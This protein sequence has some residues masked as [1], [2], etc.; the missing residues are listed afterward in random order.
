MFFNF[1]AR[2]LIARFYSPADYGFFNLYFTILSIFASIGAIGLKAGIQR[3][4][5]YHLGKDEEE[6]VPAIIGWGIAI[7]L[8]G[9]FVSGMVLFIFANPI[10]SIF[11][12]DPV[13]GYYFKIAAIAVPFYILTIALESIF[14][15][16][17]RTKERILFNV[18]GRN[19]LILA[20]ILIVGSFAFHFEKMMLAV[21]LSFIFLAISF[22]IYYLKKRKDILGIKKAFKW[23]ISIGKKLFLFSLPL[24]LVGLS[25]RVM[26][27]ADTIMIGYFMTED[28]VGYYQAA[29]PLSRFISTAL[30]VTLFIYS[31]ISASLYAKKKIR[32]NQTIYTTITK[33]LCFGTLPIALTFFFY[34]RW[35]LNIF[36]VEYSV[37]IIPLQILT[38]VY[39]INNFMGP[40]GATLTAYGKTKFLMYATGTAAGL[41]VILNGLLIP[42]YDIMGAAIATGVSNLS[43][44]TIRV[45]K[46][47]DISGIHSIRFQV[48]KPIILSTFLSVLFFY[49]ITYLFAVNIIIVALSGISFYGI[50][51]FS[52]I[53]TK[54]FSEN[55]IKLLLLVEKRLGLDLTKIKKI[56]KKFI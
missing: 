34:P 54:S 1:V 26:G 52:I 13:L 41:N 27:W 17:Q 53:S 22:F 30:T 11:S 7:S 15:G 10:A 56:L 35:I 36:G 6:K 25:Q 39:F 3:N 38:I 45:K 51:L 40:N 14:R 16:V 21:S 23:D 50:F 43:I 32:E 31:P 49:S 8:A 44:N 2:V 29:K 18:L 20:S 37:A 5:A 19:T 24:L 9:G 47:K 12:D 4:I 33:W 48:L 28:F 55:D 42:F 46:L